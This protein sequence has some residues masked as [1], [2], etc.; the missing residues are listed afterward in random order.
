MNA[1][2]LVALL[3]V[4]AA[5]ILALVTLLTPEEWGAVHDAAVTPIGVLFLI[6]ATLL[7]LYALWSWAGSG[8]SHG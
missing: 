3:V 2:S 8:A 5:I 6:V 4:V 1:K 7:I